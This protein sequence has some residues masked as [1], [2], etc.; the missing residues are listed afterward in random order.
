M[1]RI[2]VYI[3]HDNTPAEAVLSVWVDI[4]WFSMNGYWR[5]PNESTHFPAKSVWTNGKG[6]YSFASVKTINLRINSR[7]LVREGCWK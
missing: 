2:P 6:S 1:D 5:D 3:L 4:V 7:H